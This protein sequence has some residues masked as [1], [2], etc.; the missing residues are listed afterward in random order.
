MNRLTSI[1][2]ALGIL[3]ILLVNI[4]A[5]IYKSRVL[6]ISWA[7]SLNLIGNVIL[8]IWDVPDSAKWFAFMLGYMSI[9]VSSVIYGWMNDI[10][11]HDAQ[12]RAIVLLFTNLFSQQFRAWLDR[13][14]FP[15]V[16]APRYH[17]CLLYTS[18]CV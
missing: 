2:P 14:V 17:T 7:Y 18:R 15:T 4:G 10:M 9:T 5:D 11:R 3:F 12:E 13:I 16:D 6:S 8:A 1:P